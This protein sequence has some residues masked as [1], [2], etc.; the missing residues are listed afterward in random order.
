MSAT[1]TSRRW[2]FFWL[3]VAIAVVPFLLVP[4]LFQ[5]LDRPYPFEFGV[6]LSLL[7]LLLWLMSQGAGW[8]PV[9]KDTVVI[10]KDAMDAVSAHP[11][12]SYLFI[13]VI[14]R[15]EAVLPSYPIT[16]EFDVEG[17]DTNTVG[18]GKISK[19][20]VRATC[21]I[22]DAE[23]FV[24]TT[25]IYLDRIK[26]MEQAEKL[27]RNEITLWRKLLYEVAHVYVDDIVRDVVWKWKILLGDPTLVS[28]LDYVPPPKEDGTINLD[29]DPY[30][31]SRNRKP[32]A[33]RVKAAIRSALEQSRLGFSIDPLVFEVIELDGETI[34]RATADRK[35]EREKATHEAALL[36]DAI[37][38]RGTAE[39]EVRVTTLA[40]LLKV[41]IEDYNIPHTD[42][43]IAHVVRSVLYSDGE[44]LWSAAL[45]TGKAEN[46]TA[47]AA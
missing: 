46:G 32:L 25:A 33:D 7:G 13:P 10:V 34:K 24:R 42:P 36:G 15:V 45:D 20:R 21:R 28:V 5:L 16:F 37:R 38:E 14:H 23:L 6:L 40:K 41:L 30:S 11:K 43:L 26:Q 4:T 17:I 22:T 47:K 44:I 35:K 8:R 3:F 29:G 18:L 39:G 19:I 1:S 2:A 9:E 27:K 31:L 12:G